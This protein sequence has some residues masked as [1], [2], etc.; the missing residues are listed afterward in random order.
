[1]KV[2]VIIPSYKVTKHIIGVIEQIGPEV[3]SIYVVD[4]CC[5]HNSGE[6]VK[7]NC[8]DSRVKVIRHERNLGVG[9]LLR[10]ARKIRSG[11]YD[12]VFSVHKSWRTA[13]L[14][15]LSGIKVRYGFKEARGRMLYTKTA[16]RGDLN[17]EV[18][19]NLAILRNIGFEPKNLDTKMQ[20][21]LSDSALE[22]AQ[23]L[24]S[25]LLSEIQTGMRLITVAPG[26]VWL[27]KRWPPELFAEVV[28]EL[29]KQG[30]GVILIG[31]PDDIETGKI[32]VKRCNLNNHSVSELPG[33][34]LDLTG[35]TDL[36]TSVAVLSKTSLAVVND[37]SP[38]HFASACGV[39][40]VAIFCATSPDFGF[41]PWLVP[42][43][44]LGVEELSCRPCRRHGG[45]YC[46][47]GTHACRSGISPETVIGAIG[48]LLEPS[49]DAVS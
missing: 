20:I 19:R 2:A 8:R 40:I 6:F 39:P 48:E 35:K 37:S 29:V 47:T 18:L 27:T 10:M 28:L 44:V 45:N 31:G 11:Q 1:M 32:I 33:R 36:M 13:L 24:V 22:K 23:N 15:K 30:F 34:V 9:G 17:H 46:P 25:P 26:S 49:L 3:S 14:L 5:P 42:S 16:P 43:R 38:L 7:Q 41:G 4:D 12:I 21:G